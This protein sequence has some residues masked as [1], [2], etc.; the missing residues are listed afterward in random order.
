MPDWPGRTPNVN[1]KYH[2]L[3]TDVARSVVA[4]KKSS[5]E[6]TQCMAARA[7]NAEHAELE[8]CDAA[9]Q[10]RKHMLRLAEVARIVVASPDKRRRP[11]GVTKAE[12]KAVRRLKLTQTARV[13]RKK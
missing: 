10:D 2:N 5:D 6:L 3:R 8:D 1:D 7:V 4:L 11:R 12:F 9:R 13:R